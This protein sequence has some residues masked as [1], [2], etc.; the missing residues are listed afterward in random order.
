MIARLVDGRTALHIASARGN[1]EIVKILMDRSIE[2]EEAEDEKEDLRRAQ[3]KAERVAKGQ[4]TETDEATE[5]ESKEVG[6][7]DAEDV[8]DEGSEV[9]EITL[10]SE[11]GSDAMT[12][13]SFV[14]VDNDG[15]K[16]QEVRCMPVL[17]YCFKSLFHT[18]DISYPK[19]KPVLTL[20]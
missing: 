13:G 3:R 2:N 17:I 15:T 7:E 10:E 1:A 14:K 6:D 4:L 12:M 19:K 18:K 11:E 20:Y 16:A 8:D 9:S 5:E